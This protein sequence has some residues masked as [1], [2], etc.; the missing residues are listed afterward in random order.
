M[1]FLFILSGMSID[2][3]K[4]L[5][6]IRKHLDF[7]KF[8]KLFERND[9]QEI[10]NSTKIKFNDNPKVAEHQFSGAHII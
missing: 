8:F 10:I 9:I 4:K 5:E 2:N 7:I 3:K 1:W 6:I